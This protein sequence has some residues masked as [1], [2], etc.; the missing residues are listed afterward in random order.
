[1]KGIEKHLLVADFG[2]A[3][4][5]VQEAHCRSC[6]TCESLALSVN[7]RFPTVPDPFTLFHGYT[8][9]SPLAIWDIKRLGTICSFL[10]YLCSVFQL[11]RVLQTLLL[12]AGCSLGTFFGLCAQQ[13][14]STSPGCLCLSRDPHVELPQIII[15]MI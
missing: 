5:G 3:C 1:M 7:A 10:Q 12:I 13:G 9:T 4:R 11:F 14:D 15:I 8:A 2:S 6:G